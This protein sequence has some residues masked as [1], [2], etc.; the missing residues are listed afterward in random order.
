MTIKNTLAEILLPTILS[1]PLTLYAQD[2]GMSDEQMQ[3]MMEG[4]GKMQDCMAKIDQKAM[5]EMAA[6]GEKVH[7]EIKQLCAAGKRDE[8]QKKA[9][10]YGRE[11]A[12]SKDMQAMR[13]CGDMAKGMMPQYA[14]SAADNK[15]AHVCDGM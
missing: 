12:A 15:N 8:A 7:A 6:K 9:M 2:Q 1:L 14:A 10:E 3:Q 13:K 5:D 11:M 4:A